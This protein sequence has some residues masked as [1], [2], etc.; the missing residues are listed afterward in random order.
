LEELGLFLREEAK[1]PL[2]EENLPKGIDS[3]F[4]KTSP[5]GTSNLFPWGN[6]SEA[7]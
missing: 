2:R 1:P 4:N 7:P 6:S 5:L 3:L